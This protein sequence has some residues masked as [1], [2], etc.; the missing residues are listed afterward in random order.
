MFKGGNFS[1]SNLPQGSGGGD[2]IALAE[3]QVARLMDEDMSAAMQYLQSKGL[4]L[5]PI[6]LATV[7]SSSGSRHPQSSG[8][9]PSSGPDGAESMKQA[10]EL[11]ASFAASVGATAHNGVSVMGSL[12][13]SS[14]NNYVGQKDVRNVPIGGHIVNNNRMVEIS[15]KDV[16]DGGDDEDDKEDINDLN[17][18]SVS[19]LHNSRCGIKIRQDIQR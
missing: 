9:G 15:R 2:G 10:M 19:L 8:V 7:I 16:S 18:G 13:S 12:A 11:A 14:S 6:S 3:H 5:M 17:R 1:T 4:C